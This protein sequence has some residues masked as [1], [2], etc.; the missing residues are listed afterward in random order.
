MTSFHPQAGASAAPLLAVLL[1]QALPGV[2][3]LDLGLPAAGLFPWLPGA[4]CGVADA[5]A[6]PAA[7]RALLGHF[8]QT[9]GTRPLFGFDPATDAAL[10]AGAPAAWG[11]AAE[12][13]IRLPAAN[14]AL[15]AGFADC[16]P[17][18]PLFLLPGEAGEQPEMARGRII[19][20]LGSAAQVE[21]HDLL[22]PPDRTAALFEALRAAGG[23]LAEAAGGRWQVGGRL[24]SPRMASLAVLAEAPAG[25]AP[26]LSIPAE[27]LVHDLPAQS[28]DGRLAS[29]VATRLRLLLG[30]LPPRP[31]RLR[32]ALCADTLG[33]AAPVL[34]LDG[35]RHPA[36]IRPG[37]AGT[38]WLEAA[39]HPGGDRALVLGLAL[40]PEAGPGGFALTRI[41]LLP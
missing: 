9:G 30:A 35:M 14:P 17:P 13:L 18:E 7:E 34:F 2:R 40:P 1:A 41:E 36:R 37:P 28:A 38:A 22:V 3:A 5:A 23:A 20:L 26:P 32:I 27:A 24:I 33:L 25:F 15:L 21:R 16:A 39:I 6:L 11:E 4:F 10:L 29:G 8:R 12:R 31:W 19:L